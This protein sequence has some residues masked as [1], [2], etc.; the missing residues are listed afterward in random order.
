MFR[1]SRNLSNSDFGFEFRVKDSVILN[2]VRVTFSKDFS[3]LDF[4][5]LRE[6]TAA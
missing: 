6:F 4:I 5:F 1:D 2:E 3:T